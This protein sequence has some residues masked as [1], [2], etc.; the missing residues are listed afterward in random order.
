MVTSA[1]VTSRRWHSLFVVVPLL[2]LASACSPSTG[3]GA[4]DE[5]SVGSTPSTGAV[6][7]PTPDRA[8]TGELLLGL[9]PFPSA[10]SPEAV[11]AAFGL[12]AEEGSLIAHHFDRGIPWESLLDGTPLPATFAA[13]LRA[14]RS[15]S[16]GQGVYVALALSN[17]ARDD[18]PDGLDGAARPVSLAGAGPSTPEVQRA[19]T[20]WIDLLVA[21]L[22]PDFLNV[23]VEIDLV[24]ASDPA[25]A[26][27]WLEL[28]R[29]LYRH[30]TAT[31]PDVT[32]FASFQA[33][34]GDPAVL[35]QLVDATDLIAVSTYPYLGGDL[36][37][38]PPDYLDRFFAP[39]L[40]VA[41]AETGFPA[42]VAA[43]PEGEVASSPR[44]QDD[45]LEWL[46]GQACARDLAFLVWF[47]PTDIDI[48]A[49]G[50]SPEAAATAT[51]FATNGLYGLNGDPRPAARRWTEAR[52]TGCSVD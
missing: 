41:I 26:G 13:E 37:T 11:A 8:G 6:G 20:A 19:L 39:G 4:G 7:S 9:T 21:E 28:Y 38:P 52:E 31:Y 12:A 24:A 32:V 27:D 14:R 10:P 34:L 3:G 30:A 18:I 1:M 33:E 25:A 45:Y 36:S 22:D 23:G 49:W 48:G 42:G 29:R 15:A 2:L 40:P 17:V 44:A 35:P 51:V 47:L 43:T 5:S 50:Y 46:L 16:D